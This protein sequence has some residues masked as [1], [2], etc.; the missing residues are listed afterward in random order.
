[1]GIRKEIKDG[2]VIYVNDANGFQVREIVLA[3]HFC[4]PI[5]CA[6]KNEIK[7]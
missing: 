7:H 4:I 2:K 6:K 1:M 5:M 3:V